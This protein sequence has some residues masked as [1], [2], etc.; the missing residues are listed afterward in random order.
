M[1]SS[2]KEVIYNRAESVS[3]FGANADYTDLIQF[4][5]TNKQLSE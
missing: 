2:L 5:L 3:R 4:F 1:H